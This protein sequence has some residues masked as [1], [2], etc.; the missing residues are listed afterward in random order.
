MP[1]LLLTESEPIAVAPP[2][3]PTDNVVSTELQPE[4][5]PRQRGWGFFVFVA[6][7]IVVIFIA[8][9]RDDGADENTSAAA[10][11]ADR[12][13]GRRETTSSSR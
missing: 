10:K 13:R 9:Q 8:W 11:V 5:M 3:R 12:E 1:D 4:L 2:I 7:A 6:C